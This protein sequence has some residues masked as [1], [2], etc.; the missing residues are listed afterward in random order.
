MR[1]VAQTTADF[2]VE[3]AETDR[4]SQFAEEGAFSIIIR[5]IFRLLGR[6]FA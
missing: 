5:N 3:L 1:K 2:A 6:L 4:R